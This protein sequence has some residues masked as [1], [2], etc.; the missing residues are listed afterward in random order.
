MLEDYDR[1]EVILRLDNTL[2]NDVYHLC[3]ALPASS[4]SKVYRRQILDAL[5]NL[6][7]L[8]HEHQLSDLSE[9][10]YLLAKKSGLSD[11]DFSIYVPDFD[12][13][14]MYV[15]ESMVVNPDDN[16]TR[17]LQKSG[18]ETQVD[19]VKINHL[20]TEFSSSDPPV[21]TDTDNGDSIQSV[22]NTSLKISEENDHNDGI[23]KNIRDEIKNLFKWDN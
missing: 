22:D 15:I 20:E 23:N 21:G 4:R 1:F 2:E 17:I 14:K 3:D 6:E 16:A 13:K 5:Q 12:F 11:I 19:F 7:L 8:M 9:G 10:L 18:G